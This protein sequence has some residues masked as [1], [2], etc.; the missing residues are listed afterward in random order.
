[1]LLSKE[2]SKINDFI[3][4]FRDNLSNDIYATQEYSI[5]LVQI[6]IVSNT[7]KSDLAI[8]FLNWDKLSDEEKKKLND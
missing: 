5:K 3:D 2:M 7:N 1:M 6:P 4:K 8:Q